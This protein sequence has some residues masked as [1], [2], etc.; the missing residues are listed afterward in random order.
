MK[1]IAIILIRLYQ[2]CIS[3]LIGRCCRF[4]PSC[5]EY[6][7]E[8]IKKHGAMKG[9]FLGIKRLGK[10]HPLHPGGVDEVP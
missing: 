4:Y 2:W 8:S 9:I 5:S 6:T 10:C 3:P 1:F 7:A